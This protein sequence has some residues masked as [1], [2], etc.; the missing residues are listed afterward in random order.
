MPENTDFPYF[1]PFTFPI[2]SISSFNFSLL[3]YFAQLHSKLYSFPWDN[4]RYDFNSSKGEKQAV[5]F[6][7]HLSEDKKNHYSSLSL[8][9]QHRFKHLI[10]DLYIEE[11]GTC[12][13]YNGCYVSNKSH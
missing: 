4:G 10:P 1:S 5:A 2:V 11:T 12:L 9:G 8:L 6:Y 13:F 7:S 3:R